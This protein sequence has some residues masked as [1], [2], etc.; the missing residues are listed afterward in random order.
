LANC[1][2]GDSYRSSDAPAFHQGHAIM[3]GLLGLSLICNFR[4]PPLFYIHSFRL[5]DLGV[6]LT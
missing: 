4:F 5:S 2:F 3:I 6:N 1:F